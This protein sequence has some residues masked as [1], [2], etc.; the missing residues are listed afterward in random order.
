MMVIESDL[1]LVTEVEVEPAV[2]LVAALEFDLAVVVEFARLTVDT[3]SAGGAA[4]VAWGEK[5]V[6]PYL[7][8]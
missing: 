8:S 1:E 7:S 5:P 4:A 6:T 3:G 2:V